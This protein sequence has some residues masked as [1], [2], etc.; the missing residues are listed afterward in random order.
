MSYNKL[1]FIVYTC[2]NEVINIFT[3]KITNNIVKDKNV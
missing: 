2:A 1:T 3:I